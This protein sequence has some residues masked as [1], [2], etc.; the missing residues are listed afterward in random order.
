MSWLRYRS[1]L[2]R[3][4]ERQ[5]E[6]AMWAERYGN[7]S[8]SDLQRSREEV[9]TKLEFLRQAFPDWDIQ[10]SAASSEIR[11]LEKEREGIILTLV[12]RGRLDIG[13]AGDPTPAVQQNQGNQREA[14]VRPILDKKGWS[15]HDWA[16]KSE[17]DFHTAN[18]YLNGETNPHPSTRKKLADALGVTVDDL[19]E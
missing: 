2:Q 3:Q 5:D 4:Q 16:E 9:E 14:F 8:D 19:P 15:I 18:D 7:V 1:E 11:R 13:R 6:E 17:V 12:R 10:S